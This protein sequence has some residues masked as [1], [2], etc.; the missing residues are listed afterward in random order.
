MPT[1]RLRDAAPKTILL[2]AAALFSVF[3]LLSMFSAALQP[4]GT[5]P[6]GI[7]I[8]THP[9]WH[10]FVDAWNVANITTLVGSSI[11][12][13][14]GVVPISMLISA[15]AAYAIA[16]LRIPFGN[17][18]FLVLLLGLTLPFEVVVVPL[19]YQMQ[20][21]GLLNSRLGL[22]LPLIGLNMPFAV[23]WMRTHFQSVPSDISEASWIDGAGS[24]KAFRHI[25]LPLAVPALA[26][27]GVLMFL[28]T[29]NQFLLAIVLIDDPNKRTMAGALQGFVGAHSTDVV[30]LNAGALLIM[31]PTILVFLIFQKYF[32]QAMLAGAVKG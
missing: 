28:S 3:P 25:Q 12:L 16:Q 26:S 11:I 1:T 27:L 15:M 18:F 14:L 20:S 31:A 4:Q 30:L 23:F 5:A 17:A 10:N 9:Q 22:I 6:A 8:P 2:T 13:V 32:I 19:Y 29:W 7:S 21:L 24:W